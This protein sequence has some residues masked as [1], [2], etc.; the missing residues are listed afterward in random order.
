[1]IDYVVI[2]LYNNECCQLFFVTQ[3]NLIQ[4][5]I[6]LCWLVCKPDGTKKGRLSLAGMVAVITSLE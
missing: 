3:F 2:F 6:Q 1:M 4:L 5:S